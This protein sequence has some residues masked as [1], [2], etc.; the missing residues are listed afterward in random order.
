MLFFRKKVRM[1]TFF[2]NQASNS[3]YYMVTEM[4]KRGRGRTPGRFAA[5]TAETLPHRQRATPGFVEESKMTRYANPAIKQLADQQVRYVP[6]DVRIEQM[7]N[8]ERLMHELDPDKAYRY[9]DLCERITSYRPS[10]YPDLVIDGKDAVHDLRLFVEDVSASANLPVEQAGELVYTVDDL[11]QRFN[12]STKT[13]DRWR[14]R[15]LVGRRFRF[16]NRTRIG[17]LD[18]S[19]SR[20]VHNHRDEVRR[21]SRF[22]QMNEGERQDIV[23]KARRLAQHGACSSE[24]SRRLSK[25]FDRSPETIRYTLRQYDEQHPENAVFPKASAPLRTGTKREI[26]QHYQ[27]GT[28]VDQ[29]ASEYR[30]TRTSIYRI[31]SEVRAELLMDQPID[32][33]DSPEFHTPNSE[34][35]CLGPAPEV[36]K[37][38]GRVKPP[39]GLPPY[40]ASLYS[41]PLLTREEE[42]HYFRRMNYLK[43]K[44]ARLRDRIQGGRPRSKD[45]DQLEELLSKAVDVKNFLIRSNLRLVVSIAKRHMTPST[46]FFEMVSDGNMSLIRAIEKFDY[47]KGNKFS[48]YATWAIM[49]NYARSIPAEYKLLDR[50]RTGN[51][52]VFHAS[53]EQRGNQYEEE[54]VNTKQHQVIMTILEQLDER[55]R[56]IITHRYGLEQGTEPQTLEQ[57]GTQF[58]VTKERI[59]QLEAR[60]LQKLRKIAHEERLDIPG[61]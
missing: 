61:V 18:S 52:E 55:E 6:V 7:D 58:G 10:M 28:P 57:V 48:T 54:L 2:F 13:V 11:S 23:R 33:M 56:A 12:V 44:A 47:T 29:L 50:Y 49:K 59:R 43:F 22:S 15:G 27:R 14:K 8:A 60:A 4:A 36:D 51:D 38:G 45:L 42:A 35:A 41:I 46:N 34:R 17:F 39:P 30:R 32:Y 37:R 53:P 21:G 25:A 40:L 5:R 9:Q 20:F 26:Y 16:G 24:I 1:R 19:V 31:I 3:A